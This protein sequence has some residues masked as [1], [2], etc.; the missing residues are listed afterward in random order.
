MAVVETMG[1]KRVTDE[2]RHAHDDLEYFYLEAKRNKKIANWAAKQLGFDKKE[3][4]LE[5]ISADISKAGPKPVVDRIMAD[6]DKAKLEITEEE[7]WTKLRKFEKEALQGML[8]EQAK[9]TK[10]ELKAKDKK[11]EKDKDKAKDKSKKDKKDKDKKKKK[12]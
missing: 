6:F 8:E 4:F 3:Y 11:K 1:A 5:L 12:K 10:D 7:V 9:R 2:V